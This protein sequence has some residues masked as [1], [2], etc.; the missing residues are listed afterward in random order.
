MD[1]A[2]KGV[3]IMACGGAH[4]IVVTSESVFTFGSNQS[5]QL[6]VGKKGWKTE[7]KQELRLYREEQVV[8]SV[9]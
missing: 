5:G 4:S 3:A 6:G 7:Y 8:A 1:G 2:G 9:C